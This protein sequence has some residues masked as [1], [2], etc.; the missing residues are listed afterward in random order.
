[1]LAKNQALFA[2][3]LHVHGNITSKEHTTINFLHKKKQTNKK[4]PKSSKH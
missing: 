1:M 2:S 3:N 4:Y